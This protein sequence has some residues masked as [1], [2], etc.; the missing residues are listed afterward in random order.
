MFLAKNPRTLDTGIIILFIKLYF[1]LSYGQ[2]K[3]VFKKEHSAL[4]LP[5]SRPIIF[6]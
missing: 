3:Y 2:I 4:K 6:D 1:K 5:C